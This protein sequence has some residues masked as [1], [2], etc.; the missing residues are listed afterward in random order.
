MVYRQAIL[1]WISG[2]FVV[3]KGTGAVAAA[4]DASA[5][6]HYGTPTFP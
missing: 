6:C 1:E 5:K 4:L 2:H 3:A